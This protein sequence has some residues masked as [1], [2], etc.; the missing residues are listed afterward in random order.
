MTPSTGTSKRPDASSLFYDR[1]LDYV[2]VALLAVE[3]LVVALLGVTVLQDVDRSFTAEVAAEVAADGE[4]PLGL[5]EQ[6]FADALY[7]LLSWGGGGLVAT[8]AVLLGGAVWFYRYRGRVRE[9]LADGARPPRWHAPVFGGVLA[10]S[11]AFV[12][13]AQVGGGAVAGYLSTGSATVDG[14][15]AGVVFLAPAYVLWGAVAAGTVAAGTPAIAFVV[16]IAGLVSLAVDVVL[17]GSA[18]LLTGLFT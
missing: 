4:I 13:F 9:R 18:G 3:G 16:G 7:S 17:A 12:P 14:V 2:V 11:L 5:T 6:A 8:G 10:T 1:S 15:V